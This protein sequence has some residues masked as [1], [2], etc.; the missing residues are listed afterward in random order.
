M[1]NKKYR[2]NSGES[3][4][5][6]YKNGKKITAK[7]IIVFVVVNNLGYNRFGIVTSKKVG[8]AVHRN[9][10]KRR[11]RSIVQNHLPEIKKGFDLVIIARFNIKEASYAALEK[12]FLHVIKKAGLI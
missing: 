2:I 1:L 4:N 7:Y 8:N 5:F 6:I 10:A 9:L 3:Y 11:M 12:N